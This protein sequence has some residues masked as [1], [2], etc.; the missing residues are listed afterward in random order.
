VRE[1]RATGAEVILFTGVDV[2]DTPLMR[3]LRGRFATYYL[4]VRSIADIHGCHLVDQW[5]MQGLRDWRAWAEDRLHMNADGH[6]LVAARVLDVLGVPCADDW[7]MTW[8][9]AAT[10]DPRVKRREDAQWLREHL[11]PWVGRRLRGTSSGDAVE[12]KRPDLKP[13]SDA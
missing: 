3:Y 1:L 7:R 4:H 12:A 6:R 10:V 11:V 2:R 13:W 9:A 5:S 8:P